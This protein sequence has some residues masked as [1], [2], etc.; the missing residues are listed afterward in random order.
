MSTRPITEHE[1][2]VLE[3]FARYSQAVRDLDVASDAREKAE[4]Q[5]REAEGSFRF[6]ARGG[7]SALQ[8]GGK[9]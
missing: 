9:L 6:L 2:R 3:A 5:V 8:K 7:T 1:E 4:A